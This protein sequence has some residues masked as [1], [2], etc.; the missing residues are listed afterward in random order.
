MIKLRKNLKVCT[1]KKSTFSVFSVFELSPKKKLKECLKKTHIKF[2]F[3]FLTVYVKKN[4]QALVY[5]AEK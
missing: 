4:K 5:D 3:F 2:F 1:T